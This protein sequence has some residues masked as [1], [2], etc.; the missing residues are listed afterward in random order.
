MFDEKTGN[1]GHDNMARKIN[2][3]IMKN[4]RS[5]FVVHAKGRKRRKYIK[6]VESERYGEIVYQIMVQRIKEAQNG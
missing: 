4:A 1:P 6:R 5:S 2:R 3:S